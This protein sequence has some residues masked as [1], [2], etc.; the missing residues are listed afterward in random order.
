MDISKQRQ[1]LHAPGDGA[2]DAHYPEDY[3]YHVHYSCHHCSEQRNDGKHAPCDA[4]D[5]DHK[6]LIEVMICKAVCSVS[7]DKGDNEAYP[8]EI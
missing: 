7:Y 8:C 2:V 5:I 6:R 1:R 3:H 4:E